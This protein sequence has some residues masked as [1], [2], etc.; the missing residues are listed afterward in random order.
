MPSPR[1]TPRL[2]GGDFGRRLI[3][4]CQMPYSRAHPGATP[5]PRR[6][7]EGDCRRNRAAPRRQAGRNGFPLPLPGSHS[8]QATRRFA[9]VSWRIGRSR[10]TAVS[11]F[12]GVPAARHFSRVE[13][14][15][16]GVGNNRGKTSVTSSIAAAESHN[17]R[18]CKE[19]MAFGFVRRG[20]P[21][22]YLPAISWIWLVASCD[23]SVFA[24]LSL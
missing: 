12:R 10:G 1:P 4:P 7:H 8:W 3:S 21:G 15:R 11:L 13:Q 14:S 17:K 16:A 22:R 9:S 20:N 18:A 6:T 19:I 2:T 23:H 24:V 5:L